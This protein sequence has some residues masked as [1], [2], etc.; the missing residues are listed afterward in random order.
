MET[1]RLPIFRE[2]FISLRGNLT[3]GQFAKKLGISRPTVGL[4][5]SGA[6]I[7]DALVLHNIA[8]KC[9]VS[10]DW[11][12][13]LSDVRSE[14]GDVRGVCN[15]TGLSEKAVNYLHTE[16][17]DEEAIEALDAVLSLDYTTFHGINRYILLALKSYKVHAGSRFHIPIGKFI[18]DSESGSFFSVLEKWGGTLLDPVEATDY[19]ISQAAYLFR[20]LLDN[21]VKSSLK[22]KQNDA[23]EE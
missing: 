12:L 16:S 9:E 23:E 18:P 5:E 19:Y 20:K 2:R 22:E 3:Q 15:Y 10:A 1:P 17:K 7:P 8:E 21:A 14:N 4:Y 6:R 13:G 11:L